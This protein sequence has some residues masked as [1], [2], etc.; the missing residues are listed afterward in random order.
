MNQIDCISDY[1]NEENSEV[2]FFPDEDVIFVEN[3]DE[4]G[5]SDTTRSNTSDGSITL[6]Y[7]PKRFILIPVRLWAFYLHPSTK[8]SSRKLRWDHPNWKK[9]NWDEVSV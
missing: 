4:D 8:A 5:I 7:L 1:S 2:V 9:G 6:R 3:E